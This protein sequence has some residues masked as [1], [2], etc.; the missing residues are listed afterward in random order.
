MKGAPRKQPI[1]HDAFWSMY[2]RELRP[3]VTRSCTSHGRRLGHAVDPDDMSSW[4]DCRVWKLIEGSANPIVPEGADAREAITRIRGALPMLTRWAHLALIRKAMRIRT[5]EHGVDQ[6]AIESLSRSRA[7]P[8][9]FERSETVR[10][11]LDALRSRVSADVRSKLAASWP[12]AEERERIADALD[13]NDKED[14]AM[15]DMIE[16]GEMK[17]NTVHQMRSRSMKRTR[18]VFEG[19]RDAAWKFLPAILVAALL[20]L[21]LVGPAMAN[22]DDDD[23]EQTGGRSVPVSVIPGN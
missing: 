16:S 23:G 3:E 19:S 18:A 17:E 9:A 8:G 15:R 13:V 6:Q 12:H 22:D 20:T 7:E 5:H 10:A 4:I 2:E 14:L 1:D 11:G 21:T